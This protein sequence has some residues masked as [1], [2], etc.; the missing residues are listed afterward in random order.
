[1]VYPNSCTSNYLCNS[2]IHFL[3][4]YKIMPVRKYVVTFKTSIHAFYSTMDTKRTTF[5][6]F[7]EFLPD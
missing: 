2:S 4:A 5:S 7:T 1:M 3:F 6:D